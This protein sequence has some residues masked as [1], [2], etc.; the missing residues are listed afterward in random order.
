[1]RPREHHALLAKI[2]PLR[3]TAANIPDARWAVWGKGGLHDPL[4]WA[5]PLVRR[6]TGDD[7]ISILEL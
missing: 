4:S 6:L 7:E 3:R 2:P 1:M 5:F